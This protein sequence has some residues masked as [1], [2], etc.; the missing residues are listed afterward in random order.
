[1]PGTKLFVGLAIYLSS[2]FIENLINKLL[3]SK[4]PSLFT[5]QTQNSVNHFAIQPFNEFSIELVSQS[6]SQ[7]VRSAENENISQFKGHNSLPTL[8]SLMLS[9]QELIKFSRLQREVI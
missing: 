2:K 8:L 7:S 3:F 5:I 6:V 4:L 1:M 9:S